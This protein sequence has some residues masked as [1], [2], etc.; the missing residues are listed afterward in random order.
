V[1]ATIPL[2]KNARQQ[3]IVDLLGRLPVRSQTE[4]SELL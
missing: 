2:T 4:L 3:K 1:T